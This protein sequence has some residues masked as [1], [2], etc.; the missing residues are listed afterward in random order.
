MGYFTQQTTVVPIDT[1]DLATAQ[2]KVTIR[3]LTYQERQR[4]ISAAMKITAETNLAGRRGGKAKG[5]QPETTGDLVIDGAL[6][7][8]EQVAAC[9]VSWEGPGFEGQPATRENLLRL[10]PEI[11]DKI[12]EAADRLNQGLSDEEKN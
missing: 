5:A 7:A 6:M 10:P 8:A 4:C 2:D 3:K 1:D 11:V 9:L 12:S